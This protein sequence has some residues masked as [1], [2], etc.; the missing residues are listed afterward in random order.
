MSKY[1]AVP[2]VVDNVRFA[3]KREAARYQELKLL[4]QSGVIRDLVLQPPFDLIVNGVT[5]GKYVGDFAYWDNEHNQRTIEDV[6]GVRT[7]VYKLKKRMV[8]AQYGMTITEV[9]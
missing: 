9:S 1:R 8:E 5:V 2:T 7:P 6:K 3:S 4:E